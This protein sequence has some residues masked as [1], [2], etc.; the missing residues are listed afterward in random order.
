M[1]ANILAYIFFIGI[2]VWFWVDVAWTILCI[3]DRIL[4]IKSRLT[5]S[6]SSEEDKR[7]E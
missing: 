6:P 5:A 7:Q 3:I 1:F 2:T 4:I